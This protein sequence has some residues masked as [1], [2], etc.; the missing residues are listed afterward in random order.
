MSNHK[1]RPGVFVLG[2]H[3]SGTSAATLCLESLGLN[4]CLPEDRI[5]NGLGNADHGESKTV[6]AQNDE[7][8]SINQASWYYPRHLEDTWTE[9][10]AVKR[11]QSVAKTAFQN[12]Y[13]KDPW[14]LKDPRLCLTMPFWEKAL[15]AKPLVLIVARNPIEIAESLKARGNRVELNQ[16]RKYYIALW[17]R[18]M[19]RALEN[20]RDHN[21][22]VI[23]YEELLGDW[24]GHQEKLLRWLRGG[25]IDLKDQTPTKSPLKKSLRHNNANGRIHG[26]SLEQRKLY[27]VLEV[28]KGEHGALA[29][30]DLGPETAYTQKL[31]AAELKKVS[32]A[33]SSKRLLSRFNQFDTAGSRRKL[34]T[35]LRI[36]GLLIAACAAVVLLSF[37]G[38]AKTINELLSNAVTSVTSIQHVLSI[39]TDISGGEMLGWIAL[40]LAG[41]LLV[42]GRRLPALI[43]LSGLVL[44]EIVAV[45]L[46]VFGTVGIDTDEF[47]RSIMF[48]GL[49][50]FMLFKTFG[51]P[52]IRL[53]IVMFGIGLACGMILGE[54]YFNEIFPSTALAVVLLG[55]ALVTIPITLGEALRNPNEAKRVQARK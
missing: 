50:G 43:L 44:A 17:E 40:L 7:L 14:A 51:Q 3:R 41:T 13:P 12:T 36:T 30:P 52:F 23:H 45:A 55:M 35:G 54:I 5:T 4:L 6:V 15:E 2:M 26:L 38:T 49:I 32:R 21:V 9:E 31:F 8:L 11:L 53:V 47:L 27:D 33:Y 25:G 42:I 20:S 1:N 48:L 37:F 29:V 39:A 24:Q 34:I 22:L 10:P 19:R 28:L 46:R 18:Y 16:G